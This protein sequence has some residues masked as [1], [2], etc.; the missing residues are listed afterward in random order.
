VSEQPW[1]RAQ[2]ARDK[3]VA[4]LLDHPGVNMIDI[5]RQG[6]DEG[7]VLRVHVRADPA[8]TLEIPSELDGIPVRVVRGE[9]YPEDPA[10]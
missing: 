4:L 6:A 9:Y 7:L 8:S 3:L 1:A 5:G 2:E 10:Q